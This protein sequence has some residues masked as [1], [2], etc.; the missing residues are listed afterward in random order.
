[1]RNATQYRAIHVIDAMNPGGA[2]SIICSIIN[3]KKKVCYELIVLR[4]TSNEITSQINAP[5]KY[6]ALANG[7]RNFFLS[8]IKLVKCVTS[9]RHCIWNAH[10][11]VS[12]LYL[13]IIKFLGIIIG[14]RFTLIVT[15]HAIPS[16]L[17]SKY[18]KCFRL[19]SKFADAFVV[20][21]RVNMK[22]LEQMKVPNGKIHFIPIGSPFIDSCPKKGHDIRT[23]FGL[24]KDSIIILNVARMVPKKGQADIIRAMRILQEKYPEIPFHLIIVGNGPEQDAIKTLINEYK[25]QNHV[26][27]SGQRLDLHNFYAEARYFVMP[28]LDESMGVVIYEALAFGLHVIAYDSGSIRE[29]LKDERYGTLIKGDPALIADSVARDYQNPKKSIGVDFLKEYSAET[30]ANRYESLYSGIHNK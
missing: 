7:R 13:L 14:F 19:L 11:Q 10:L 21:D 27:L 6:T 17:S 8:F 26:T 2:Q 30:M 9:N 29:V 15:L 20:E 18:L 22:Y 28:C 25:L 12:T 4:K 16:Q 5:F 24:S 1:M 3:F 23:E